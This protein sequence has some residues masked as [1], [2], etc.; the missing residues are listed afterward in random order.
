MRRG[1]V[2]AAFGGVL[3]KRR[4][5]IE[6]AYFDDLSRAEIAAS[7]G[8]AWGTVNSRFRLAM[9]VLRTLS[10]LVVDA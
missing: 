4:Q 8:V 10:E 3:V 5:V 1:R 2:A 7:L 6:L 9:G